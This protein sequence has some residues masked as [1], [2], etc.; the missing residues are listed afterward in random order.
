MATMTARKRAKGIRYTAPIRIMRQGKIIQ[1]ESETFD[2]RGTAQS[3]AARR[4][5]E[6]EQSFRE[7]VDN[8]VE[9]CEELG[10]RSLESY[11]E[12]PVFQL[13]LSISAVNTPFC[14]P[15]FKL[16]SNL[17]NIRSTLSHGRRRPP[18]LIF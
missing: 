4:E 7:A 5:E 11:R 13:L 12:K 8:D 14:A 16:Y 18:S 17:A 9:T 10:V 15:E 1:T 6:L 2:S 3:W